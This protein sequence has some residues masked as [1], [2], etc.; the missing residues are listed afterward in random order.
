MA[1]CPSWEANSLLA[2]K[3]IPVYVK[4][5]GLFSVSQKSTG[6]LSPEQYESTRHPH[7]LFL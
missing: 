4:P 2:D 7:V 5:E 6:G 1:D 3:E